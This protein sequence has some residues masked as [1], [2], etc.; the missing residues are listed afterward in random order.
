MISK[1]MNIFTNHD[2][3]ESNKSCVICIRALWQDMSKT[4]EL[5]KYLY[6]LLRALNK[7][8]RSPREE[9]L[10]VGKKIIKITDYFIMILDLG[11][12]SFVN[13]YLFTE[14][15]KIPID[16]TFWANVYRF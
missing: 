8:D 9:I 6:F 2:I 13:G 11:T 3:S 15:N 5:F 1:I 16:L 7:V 14:L 4:I 12:E 10:S